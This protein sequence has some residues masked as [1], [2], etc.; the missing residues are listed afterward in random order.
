MTP[1]RREV[2]NLSWFFICLCFSRKIPSDQ[3]SEK[4][5]QLVLRAK[6]IDPSIK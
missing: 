6:Y 2:I 3:R 5:P 1:K 4:C